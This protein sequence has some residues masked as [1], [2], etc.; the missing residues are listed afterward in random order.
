MTEEDLAP[1][2]PFMTEDGELDLST[3]MFKSIPAGAATALTAAFDPRMSKFNGAYLCDNQVLP[4]T[5][6]GQNISAL[7]FAYATDKEN[8]KRLWDLSNKLTGEN[9]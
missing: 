2:K 6:E 1:F 3:G 7:H 5:E 8:A 4:V 9:F